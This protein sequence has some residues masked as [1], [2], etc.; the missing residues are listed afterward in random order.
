MVID[1]R[2]PFFFGRRR[3]RTLLHLA[4]DCYRLVLAKGNL[5]HMGLYMVGV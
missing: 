5:D 2:V 1:G 4:M 3:E